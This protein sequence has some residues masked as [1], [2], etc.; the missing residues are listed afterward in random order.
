MKKYEKY[1]HILVKKKKK[2]LIRSYNI[3]EKN[4]T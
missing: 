4:I 3:N 1:V 2:H